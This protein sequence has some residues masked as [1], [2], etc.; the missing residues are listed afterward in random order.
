M[1]IFSYIGRVIGS[2][3]KVEDDVSLTRWRIIGALS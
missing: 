1:Q 2:R 3:F